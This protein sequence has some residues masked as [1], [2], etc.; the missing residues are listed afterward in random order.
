MGRGMVVDARLVW[1]MGCREAA[2]AVPKEPRTHVRASWERG[3]G[4]LEGRE[5]RKAFER[6]LHPVPARYRCSGGK[7]AVGRGGGRR[8]TVMLGS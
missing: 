1:V 2:C 4:D 6:R 7:P 8:G 3:T 5:R